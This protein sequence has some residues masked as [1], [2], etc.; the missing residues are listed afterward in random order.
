M[1][2][3]ANDFKEKFGNAKNTVSTT[4]EQMKLSFSSGLEQMR[5]TAGNILNNIGST[6]SN[7]FS[8]AKSTV[9]TAIE[10]IK[11]FFDFE[12]KLPDIKLPHFSISPKDWKFGDLLEGDIPELNIEWYAKGGV[13]TKPTAFGMNGNSLMVG[14]EAGAEAIAPIST[15]QQYVS[16]AV[17]ANNGVIAQAF[18]DGIMK[19]ISFMQSS[20]NSNLQVVLDSGVLVGEIAPAMDKKLGSLTEKRSRGN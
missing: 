2:V 10:K 14:G 20:Q 17:A 8:K 1:T 3:I 11:G 13:M 16:E 15:L 7:T 9:Q 18:N 5:N 12:W 19:L 6:F 4:F